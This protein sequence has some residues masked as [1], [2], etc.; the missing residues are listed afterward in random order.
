MLIGFY[1]FQC[2][3]NVDL[4][5]FNKVYFPR[6]QI[7]EAGIVRV[8]VGPHLGRLAPGRWVHRRR[9]RG[10]ATDRLGA[11]NLVVLN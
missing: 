3:F 9:L 11:Q 7:E 8:C 4:I 10:N 2:G 1:E 6:P 5:S